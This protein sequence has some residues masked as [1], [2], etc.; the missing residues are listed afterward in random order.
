MINLFKEA[1]IICTDKKQPKK[2][3][4][5]NVFVNFNF[6]II[7]IVSKKVKENNEEKWLNKMLPIRCVIWNEKLADKF[8]ENFDK[9]KR[10]YITILGSYSF[11]FEESKETRYKA[12]GS[13]YD[14]T[15]FTDFQMSVS[16]FLITHKEIK[17]DTKQEKPAKEAI[18]TSEIEGEDEIPF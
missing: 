2:F 5:D 10:N 16:D 7:C 15:L 1:K 3:I 9:T 8:L 11:D 12:D 4:K 13:D 6:D 18:K 17:E 14:K